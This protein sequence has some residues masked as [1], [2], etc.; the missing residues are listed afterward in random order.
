MSFAAAGQMPGRSLFGGAQSRNPG[1]KTFCRGHY[2]YFTPA[3]AE[4]AKIP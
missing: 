2:F 3:G 4:I 1:L